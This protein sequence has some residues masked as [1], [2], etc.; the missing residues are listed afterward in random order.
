[1]AK[2]QT[3][4]ACGGDGVRRKGWPYARTLNLDKH[5][6]ERQIRKKNWC[7]NFTKKIKDELWVLECYFYDFGCEFVGVDFRRGAF[8]VH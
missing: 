7:D 2:K 3:V 6:S 1:M 4:V 5:M 8:I